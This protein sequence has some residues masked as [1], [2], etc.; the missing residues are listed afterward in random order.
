MASHRPSNFLPK[1]LVHC[2]CLKKSKDKE[3]VL[4]TD[5]ENLL[6]PVALLRKLLDTNDIESL[7][8]FEQLQLHGS[9]ILKQ[10]RKCH[11]VIEFLRRILKEK[12]KWD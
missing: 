2:D 3:C 8:E 12:F 5:K 10:Y 6:S 9:G 7:D 11:P 4:C 1:N